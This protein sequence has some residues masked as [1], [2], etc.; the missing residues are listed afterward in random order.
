MKSKLFGVEY[1]NYQF[2]KVPAAYETMR[3]DYEPI[4]ASVRA[5]V[6]DTMKESVGM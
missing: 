2:V 1:I 4:H 6:Y 5:S 3:I